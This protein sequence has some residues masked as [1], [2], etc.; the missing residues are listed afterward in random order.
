MT[1]TIDLD[2]S[3]MSCENCVGF[4]TEALEGVEGVQK[5]QVDLQKAQAHIEADADVKIADL[6]AALEEAGY[7]GQPA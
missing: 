4:A 7:S 6:Q 5:V 3:G 2:I 1:Q